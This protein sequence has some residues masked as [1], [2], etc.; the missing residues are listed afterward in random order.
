[1]FN[2]T[3]GSDPRYFGQAPRESAS[4]GK[5]LTG[6]IRLTNGTSCGL[7]CTGKQ[8]FRLRNT[9]WF[10]DQKC[11]Y[12]CL[13]KVPYPA[14]G[15]FHLHWN[16]ALSDLAYSRIADTWLFLSFWYGA[17]RKFEIAKFILVQH[18]TAVASNRT[19]NRSFNSKTFT[20]MLSQSQCHTLYTAVL[21]YGI[22]EPYRKYCPIFSQPPLRN[23]LGASFWPLP[24]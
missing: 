3:H 21:F 24:W 2:Q 8:I 17:K 19:W 5:L 14:S 4:H 16:V 1:M 22:L 15:C 10:L 6:F 13:K 11:N 7:S 9:R 18:L 20:V 12:L 23:N